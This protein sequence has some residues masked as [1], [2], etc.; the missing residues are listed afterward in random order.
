[1]IMK[2]RSKDVAQFSFVLLKIKYTIE[3]NVYANTLGMVAFTCL[4]HP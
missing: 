2:E 3:Y 4:K 1:M